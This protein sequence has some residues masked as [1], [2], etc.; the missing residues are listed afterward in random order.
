MQQP[1][2]PS[3]QV[4][5][6][7]L[8]Q[9]YAR[10]EVPPHICY[11]WVCAVLAPMYATSLLIDLAALLGNSTWAGAL[12]GTDNGENY[13]WGFATND[14]LAVWSWANTGYLFAILSKSSTSLV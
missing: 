6:L 4:N 3:C 5:G 2:A 8:F 11:A 9:L 1:H 7:H 13:L 10:R 12:T 14:A